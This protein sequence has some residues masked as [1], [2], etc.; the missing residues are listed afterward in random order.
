MIRKLV[1][2]ALSIL[3]VIGLTGCATDLGAG[4]IK[5]LEDDHEGIR[6]EPGELWD[7]FLEEANGWLESF[8]TWK[9]GKGY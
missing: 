9:P 1:S 7:T 2:A 8:A 3:L 5:E 6:Q 4:I